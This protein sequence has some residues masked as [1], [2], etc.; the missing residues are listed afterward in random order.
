MVINDRQEAIIRFVNQTDQSIFLTGK[1]GT[2]KTTLLRKI[3]Q[4]THKNTVVVAP[5]GI[6]ALNAGGVTIHSMFQLAPGGYVPDL[7][8]IADP[9]EGTRLESIASLNKTFKM[10]GVKQSVIRA[11]DLLVIDEVSMLRADLLDAMDVVMRRV[12]GSEAPFGGVQVFFIGDLLQLPPVVKHE[13]WLILKKYY[14]GMF[15]FHSHVIQK[16]KPLYIE[17]KKIFRQTEDKFIHVLNNL[18]NNIIT[19]EDMEMFRQ[20]VKSEIDLK[21]YPGYIY[22]TTHNK[23]ADDINT[24]SLTNI[25]EKSYTYTAEIEGDFPEKMY[26]M[27]EKLTLKVGGQIMFTKNDI[28]KD[29][30]FYNGKMGVV[31][32]LSKE[33][34]YVHFP[35][36]NYRIEVSKYEWNNV[37][38]KINEIT[39]E[40]GEEIIGTFAHYPLKLAWAITVHKSQGL[41]FEKAILDIGD[42]FQPGQAYVALSRLRS[43]DGLVLTDVLKTR[44]IQNAQDV[45]SYAQN[46]ADDNT[47]SDALEV[48]TKRF[49]YQ[50]LKNSFD[51][52]PLINLWKNHA[53]TYNDKTVHSEKAKHGGWAKTQYQCINEISEVSGKFLKWIDANFSVEKVDY[54]TILT[55]VERAYEHFFLKIDPVLNEVLTKIEE[56]K[57]IKR[58]KEYFN[59]LSEIEEVTTLSIIRIARSKLLITAYLQGQEINKTNLTDEFIKNYRT[60]KLEAI[61]AIMKRGKKDLAMHEDNEIEDF[62]YYV[63]KPKKEKTDKKSTYEITYELWLEK[64]S[65]HE[66]AIE[67]KLST[68]T[69]EG[70]LARLIE[71]D[72]IAITDVMKDNK[73]RA[74][75]AIFEGSDIGNLTE[76]KEKVGDK[77]SYGELKIY[78]AS[79]AK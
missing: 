71:D 21:Q 75:E 72:K 34:I 47:I 12:R 60:Q 70:H 19:D 45:M 40:V 18:R 33:E 32:S 1:A 51:F 54:Q 8:Y 31:E 50:Y 37:R 15:F 10:S 30:K 67:R 43:M 64:K 76:M 59:E 68:T 46:E 26:P 23:M 24:K 4:S 66:I 61:K 28:S 13:E 74:L 65:S 79:I 57:R 20:Y 36:E 16:A 25:N 53:S 56:L 69:V 77:F 9:N 6:A 17:L 14:Q 52:K 22:L 78:R 39:K 7:T 42:V 41:T 29:K 44:G 58:V 62:S 2:G 55:K 49:I 27:D 63:R 35:D 11:M 73:I 3:I 38:Y 48:G 5:T